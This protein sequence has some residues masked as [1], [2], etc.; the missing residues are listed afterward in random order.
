MS[1]LLFLLKTA[2]ISRG[3]VELT[4][5]WVMGLYI[6]IRDD[7]L[8]LIANSIMVMVDDPVDICH[9]CVLYH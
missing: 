5:G 6:P 4:A 1:K 3:L 8:D 7:Q 2:K 9:N